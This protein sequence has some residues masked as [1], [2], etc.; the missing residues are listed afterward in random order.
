M[1]RSPAFNDHTIMPA[2]YSHESGDLSPPL[3][4]A[5]PPEEVVELT[6]LCEDPDAPTGTFAHWLLA[7]I[8]PATTGVDAGELPTGAVAGRNDFGAAGYGGPMPPAG[9]DPHR[10]FF[11]LYG[12]AEPSGLG[13]GFTAEDLRDAVQDKIIASGTLVGTFVR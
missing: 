9:D 3:E 5:S 12:L 1:L 8:D 4:W 10:Y 6:L 13:T 11:R 2:E 7:G